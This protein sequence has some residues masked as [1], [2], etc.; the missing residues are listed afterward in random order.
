MSLRCSWQCSP[1]LC[2]VTSMAALVL[3]T[4]CTLGAAS[5]TAIMNAVRRTTMQ[6]MVHTVNCSTF[7]V[8]SYRLFSW[9]RGLIIENKDPKVTKMAQ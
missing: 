6:K 9:K 5:P 7:L 4:L 8:G 1:T 3:S 2:S